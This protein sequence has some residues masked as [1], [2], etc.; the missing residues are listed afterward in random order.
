MIEAIIGMKITLP[1]NA[2]MSFPL[3]CRHIHTPHDSPK[4]DRYLNNNI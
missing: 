4:T 1:A 2:V 3:H